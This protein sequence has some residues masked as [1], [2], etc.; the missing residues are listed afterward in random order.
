MHEDQG[1]VDQSVED[2]LNDLSFLYSEGEI[3]QENIKTKQDREVI[4]AKVRAKLRQ[5]FIEDGPKQVRAN[6]RL[7]QN[8]LFREEVYAD[9]AAAQTCVELFQDKM[10]WTDLMIA[11][12]LALEN[13]TTMSMITQHAYRI[14]SIEF[15]LNPLAV[16]ARKRALRRA[17]EHWTQE[18]SP[19]QP[20]LG[21]SI[22]TKA[23]RRY[24]RFIRDP[25]TID[26]AGRLSVE[27]LPKLDDLRDTREAM[28]RAYPE[29]VDPQYIIRH[30]L[31]K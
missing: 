14:F 19:E 10:D 21:H 1:D 16:A 13:I 26:L 9:Y 24:M 12:H 18:R 5:R 30:I 2:Y 29:S 11:I 3:V 28:L 31:F 6:A 22:L 25:I 15:Q 7:R 8:A 20:H 23:N 4:N 27:S 17:L